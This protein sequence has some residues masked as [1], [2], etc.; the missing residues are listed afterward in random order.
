MTSL[1]NELSIETVAQ[2][3]AAYLSN[4]IVPVTD[5]PAA[6]QAIRTGLTEPVPA[7]TPEPAVPI[8]GSVTPDHIICLEDGKK[9]KM[10]KRH[11]RT[12]FDMSPD[13]YRAKWG[14]PATYPMTAPNYAKRRADLAKEHGLGR[15]PADKAGVTD[16]ICRNCK[17]WLRWPMGVERGDCV[18]VAKM[19]CGP[20]HSCDKFE[21]LETA[22][23]AERLVRDLTPAQATFLNTG[24]HKDLDDLEITKDELSAM[25]KLG[26]IEIDATSLGRRCAYDISRGS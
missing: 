6:V 11:L 17:H 22:E 26:L 1:N 20:L 23:M 12:A 15:K 14:L 2:V 7:A 16:S 10:L 9:L 18:L 5:I 25:M 8:R 4:N 13:E 19:D 24:R 21:L 3:A